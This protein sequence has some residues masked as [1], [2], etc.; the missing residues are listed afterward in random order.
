MIRSKLMIATLFLCAAFFCGA[1][2]AAPEEGHV[3]VRL[4]IVG[5][6]DDKEPIFVPGE[7]IEARAFVTVGMGEVTNRGL[8]LHVGDVAFEFG[9]S[10]CLLPLRKTVH[11]EEGRETTEI[12]YVFPL[13]LTPQILVERDKIGY[14]FSQPGRYEV[15]AEDVIRGEGE[16][17]TPSEK[18]HVRIQELKP[19]EQAVFEAYTRLMS[20]P[21][22][23][24]CREEDFEKE[25]AAAGA[26]AVEAFLQE[27][28]T[29]YY[30]PIV[31]FAKTVY[32][33]ET[34]LRRPMANKADAL[35]R[36]RA[37]A[38]LA[39]AFQ[40]VAEST[41]NAYVRQRALFELAFA[42]TT[43]GEYE[44]ACRALNELLSEFPTGT[45]CGEAAKRLKE[46]TDH[47]ERLQKRKEEL[48][49]V[50]AVPPAPANA[51]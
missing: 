44:A 13:F 33:K 22:L 51:E 15:W 25:Y 39:D 2:Q 45:L 30:G 29:S 48:K 41:S 18:I 6:S 11:A 28:A 47:R 16:K 9:S 49:D 5:A 35:E 1:A 12:E 10:S 19:E 20:V 23:L 37:H 38:Q 7:P 40:K 34:I 26:P 4:E 24:L 27:H 31:L 17:R 8:V 21:I 43:G 42:R 46:I 14:L 36:M 32:E 3:A 50:P